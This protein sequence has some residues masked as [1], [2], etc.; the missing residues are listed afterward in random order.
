MP[1][2]TDDCICCGR[3][4]RLDDAADQPGVDGLAVPLPL[5][6]LQDSVCYL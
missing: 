2:T 3:T 4:V 6:Q 1:T 5:Y